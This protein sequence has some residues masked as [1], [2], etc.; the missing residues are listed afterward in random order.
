MAPLR[1][2]RRASRRRGSGGVTPDRP[3]A[4][5]AARPPWL[6]A[7]GAVGLVGS[8]L[9]LAGAAQPASPFASKLPGSW[10]FGVPA[11]VAGSGL[12][13]QW[14]GVAGVYAGV[15]ALLVAWFGVV[16]VCRRAG[17]ARLR[18]LV[19]VGIAWALPLVAGPP[20]MS[21][22]VYAYAAQGALADAGGQPYTT[23]VA[24]LTA[25]PYLHLVDPLWRH[26]TS[27]YGPLFLQLAR[28]AAAAARGH[29]LVAVLALRLVAVAGMALLALA[30]PPIARS[31][32]RAAA[33]AFALAV[34][35]PLLLLTLVGGA[36]N[37]ALM[38]GLLAVGVALARTGRPAAAVAF[39][40]LAAT[41]KVPAF[42]GVVFVGWSWPGTGAGWRA[43]L[44]RTLGAVAGGAA[45]VAAVTLASGWGWRW[46][47][48]ADPGK[49]VSWLDP[50]TA[51]GLLVAKVS[52]ASGLGPHT[53]G[54]VDAARVAALFVAAAI[55]LVL[56]R[57][58]DRL[59]VPAALGW[60]LFAVAVLGPIVWPWYETWGLA[61]VA[62]TAGTAARRAVL[63]ISS[64]GCFA[65]V[66]SHVAAP[67]ADA[68]TAVILLLLWIAAL[69]VAGARCRT[70]LRT[71][72]RP[73]A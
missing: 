35:N 4:G 14:L 3:Q 42:A 20:L 6:L 45:V 25:S 40:A 17:A 48:A 47:T 1:R 10:W 67:G 2:R 15:V 29:V 36:H 53:T 28:A 44:G 19:V 55:G 68:A 21:R 7:W 59:G 70:V 46:L 62:I 51:A 52:A 50:A 58:S 72:E 66:P 64:L 37:D 9:V 65:T 23:G 71:G 22:D 33:P 73:A 34:L 57:R 38:L 8:L 30:V 54:A 5:R 69:A 60:T 32:G 11:S 31:Y 27:P 16:T 39:C 43:R 61:L 41:V 56:L 12:H 63:A 13:W 26:A 18:T 24:S 49:V